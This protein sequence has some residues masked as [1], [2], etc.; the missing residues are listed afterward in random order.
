MDT[1]RASMWSC[2]Q[3][4]LCTELN[5]I[6]YLLLSNRFTTHQPGANVLVCFGGH[7]PLA[8]MSIAI[9]QNHLCCNWLCVAPG[10]IPVKPHQHTENELRPS[11]HRICQKKAVEWARR[12]SLAGRWMTHCTHHGALWA[13]LFKA[14]QN[15]FLK[16]CKNVWFIFYYVLLC[17]TGLIGNL[18]CFTAGADHRAEGAETLLDAASP[19]EVGSKNRPERSTVKGWLKDVENL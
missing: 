15:P 7:E 16:I 13:I 19:P 18:P 8:T 6:C 10:I 14:I 11:L 12:Q 4:C 2:M 5:Y 9:L 3:T 1:A 17:F